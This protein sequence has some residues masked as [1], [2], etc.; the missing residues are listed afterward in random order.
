MSMIG[1]LRLLSPSELDNL[2]RQP[3][4]IGSFVYDEEDLDDERDERDPPD[5]VDRVD[6]DK[7]W[8]GLHFLLTGSAWDGGAPLN[9]LVAGG[10]QIG[11]VDVGYGPARGFNPAEV[12]TIAD[13]LATVTLDDLRARF[14]PKAMARQEI[15]PSIW[16][17]SS[18]EEAREYLLEYFQVLIDFVAQGA[19]AGRAMIVY[20]N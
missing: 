20:V 19:N 7:A 14:D 12:R 13:S 18:V 3:E 8:H 4:G 11:D 10:R 1:N 17:G 9:F 15:Y 16:D 2:F 5:V 6:I